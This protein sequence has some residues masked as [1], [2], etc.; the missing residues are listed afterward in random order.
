MSMAMS[1]PKS[2][3][4][5]QLSA[6]DWVKAA[7]EAIVEGGVTKVAVEPLAAKLGTTKGSFYHHFENRDALIVAALEDWERSETDAVIQR[8]ELI[9]DPGERLRAVM[10]AALGDRAGA[11]RDAALVASANHPLVK[12]V[13]ERVTNRRLSYMTDLC[14][15]LGL[16]SARA[17]RRVLL[18][19]SSYIGLFDYIRAGLGD[20]AEA[21]LRAYTEELLAALV[22]AKVGK[23]S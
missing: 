5:R 18:L 1:T 4:P 16:P 23:G 19:Y 7:I 11:V 14:G 15:Q 2:N 17:R 9:P 8:L 13:V 20:L 10:A 22:P 3:G 6:S 21:E 12:P